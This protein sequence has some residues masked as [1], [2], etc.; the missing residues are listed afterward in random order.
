MKKEK[1]VI[2]LCYHFYVGQ[3]SLALKF[4]FSGVLNGKNMLEQERDY[5]N[6]TTNLSKKLIIMANQKPYIGTIM[7]YKSDLCIYHL[8]LLP[9]FIR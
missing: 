6:L 8:I 4:N 2:Y 3:R 5:F 9:N 7:M 1:L